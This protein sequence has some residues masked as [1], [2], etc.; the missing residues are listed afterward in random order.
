MTHARSRFPENI[1]HPVLA[2][3]NHSVCNAFRVLKH[4]LGA[5]FRASIIVDDKGIVRAHHVNDLG[6]GRNPGEVL[7]TAQALKSEGLCPA[8]WKKGDKHL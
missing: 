6:V 8:N 4:D 1:T 2:D 5:A 7:R 3:T